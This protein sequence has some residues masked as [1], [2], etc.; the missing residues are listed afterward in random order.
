MKRVL[1]DE[2]ARE[3]ECV[4]RGRGAAGEYYAGTSY[5]ERLQRLRGEDAVRFAG[6]VAPFFWADAPRINVWLCDDCA[7]SLGLLAPAG[8]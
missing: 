6:R 7:A 8:R 1:T 5:V 2:Q 4:H 3:R